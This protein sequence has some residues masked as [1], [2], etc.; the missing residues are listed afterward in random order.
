MAHV[1]DLRRYAL[2]KVVT[3]GNVRAQPKPVPALS[4]H[5]AG[6]WRMGGAKTGL[7]AL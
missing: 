2:R 5:A 6:D 4:M 1:A 3:H 7:I